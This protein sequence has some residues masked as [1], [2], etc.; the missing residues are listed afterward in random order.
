MPRFRVPRVAFVPVLAHPG[1]GDRRPVPWSRFHDACAAARR[2]PECE[3]EAEFGFGRGERLV[4]TAADN[5]Q[6]LYLGVE[7][8]GHFFR[9]CLRAVAEAGLPNVFLALGDARLA[10]LPDHIPPESLDRAVYLFPDPWFKTRHHHRR[11]LAAPN[12]PLIAHA[13][14][15]GGILRLR[16]DVPDYIRAADEA[17][18]AAGFES[19]YRA[20]GDEAGPPQ[21]RWEARAISEG[22]TIGEA[23]Y[24][25][26]DSLPARPDEAA[27]DRRGI[28]EH[29][30][31]A[32]A[33]AGFDVPD[34]RAGSASD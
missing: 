18:A 9:A 26:P 22:A 33:A 11:M 25:R 27:L 12:I 2:E 29:G 14:R 8:T 13:L 7:A 6:R 1:D 10:V 32:L 23:H 31:R 5:P 21:T 28:R 20:R 34:A 30:P 24:R 17:T 15:P 19:V 4:A 3:I 16:T